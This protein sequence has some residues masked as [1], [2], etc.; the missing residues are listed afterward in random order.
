MKKFNLKDE[1]IVVQRTN[2]LNAINSQKAFAISIKGEIFM[3]PYPKDEI[4]IYQG[5]IKPASTSALGT[6]KQTSIQ[7]LLGISYKVVEDG[8][9]ILIK[10]TNAWNDIIKYNILN[11]DYDD[12]TADGI[13]DFSD[14]KLE[15]IGWHATEFN[16][17]Y[18]ELSDYLEAECD[19][20]LLCVEIEEPYQFSGLG[21]I[22]DNQC[23]YDK[24]FSFSKEKIADKIKNDPDFEIK[25]LTDDEREAAEFF[26]VL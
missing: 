6:S 5:E 15:D 21:F 20:I 13:G 17:S 18:R 23:A 26:G 16:I 11:A 10:A 7:S 25:N 2:L 14:K 1:I 4:Y 3:Q 22:K 8:E 24:L 12:T 9:R 19:G